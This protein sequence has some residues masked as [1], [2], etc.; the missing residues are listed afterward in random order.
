MS[1]I[2]RPVCFGSSADSWSATPMRRRTFSVSPAMSCPATLAVPDV[3]L[4]SVVSI[5]TVVD[6]PAPF[7][8]RN[9]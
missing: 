4:S 5:R 3:G 1:R 6:L 8:P 7:G 2:S 9:P